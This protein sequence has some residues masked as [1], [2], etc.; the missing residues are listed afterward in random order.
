MK[1]SLLFTLLLAAVQSSLGQGTIN[2][3]N[4]FGSPPVFRAQIYGLDP[5]GL[6]TGQS[7]IGVPAGNSVYTGPLLAGTGFSFAVYFG[8]ASVADPSALSL[9]VSAPFRTGGAAGLISP[10][11][12]VAVPGVQP[13]ER[14]KFQIRAWDNFSGTVLSFDNAGYRGVSSMV[15]SAPLGGT[16]TDG[17]VYP[18]PITDGWTSFNIWIP[19][20]STWTLGGLG[21]LAMLFFA[22]RRDR[23]Q[24]SG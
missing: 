1:T 13:G 7:S 2:V 18:T 16:G 8:V 20:P 10:I 11:S 12:D 22:R 19:E 24:A 17:T 6:I 14:I 3:V 21:A 15:L 9:L 4:T 5:N 23:L